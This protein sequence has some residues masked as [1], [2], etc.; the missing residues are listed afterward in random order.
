[1]PLFSLQCPMCSKIYQKLLKDVLS[2]NE[3]KCIDCLVRLER[4]LNEFSTQ[5]TEIIDNGIMIKQ[6]EKLTNVEE[7]LLERSKNHEQILSPMEIL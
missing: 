4:K 6:V 5:S 3:E 2:I 1:M 7:L